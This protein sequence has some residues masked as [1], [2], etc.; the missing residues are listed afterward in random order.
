MNTIKVFTDRL[1]QSKPRQP[2]LRIITKAI[3]INLSVTKIDCNRYSYDRLHDDY[4]TYAFHST[5]Q[6]NF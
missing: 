4:T 1:R 3:Y 2:F 5:M 6:Y